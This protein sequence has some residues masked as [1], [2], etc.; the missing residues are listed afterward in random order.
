MPRPCQC[1]RCD[2]AGP[3]DKGQCRL[4]WLF[5]NDPRYR[6]LWEPDAKPIESPPGFFQRAVN[7]VGAA[8]QH[9]MAGLPT[10][11]DDLYD[12][13]MSE[14]VRCEHYN[15]ER[16]QCGLCGCRMSIKARWAEQKCPADRWPSSEPVCGTGCRQVIQQSGVVPTGG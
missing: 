11:A 3:Y 8:A 16:D 6:Q 2:Q 5:H 14:C 10:V 4:C 12:K 15:A 13:R 1:D 7:F 9:V